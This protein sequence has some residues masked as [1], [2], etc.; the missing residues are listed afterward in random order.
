MRRAAQEATLLITV[1]VLAIIVWFVIADT[2]NREIE[3]RLGFS[4][5][6]EI[7]ELGS[8]LVVAGEPCR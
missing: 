8:N 5:T 6:V 4:L 3:A 2:E 7:Q 1:V